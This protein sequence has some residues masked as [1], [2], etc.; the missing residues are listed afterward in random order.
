MGKARGR[1]AGQFAALGSAREHVAQQRQATRDHLAMIERR[2][3]GKACSLREHKTQ[4]LLAARSQHLRAKEFK[5]PI[6]H[7]RDR[8]ILLGNLFKAFE[9]RA[10][11]HDYQIAE[12]IFLVGK[13]KIDRALGDAGARRDIIEASLGKALLREDIECRVED[14]LAAVGGREG[15]PC[16]ALHRILAFHL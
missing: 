11:R 9:H 13:V 14:L 1:I 2:D 4:D 5:E 8:R 3:L 10:R 6:E 15:A 12:E 16:L 7:Q